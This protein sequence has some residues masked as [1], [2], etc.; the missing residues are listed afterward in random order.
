MSV[1]QLLVGEED[2][3]GVCDGE[4]MLGPSHKRALVPPGFL[5]V[6]GSG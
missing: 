5:N 4:E 6:Y 3:P 2:V 1:S